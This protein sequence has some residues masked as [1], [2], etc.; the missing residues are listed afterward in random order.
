[1][2]NPWEDSGLHRCGRQ[3]DLKIAVKR[4]KNTNNL[5]ARVCNATVTGGTAGLSSA[6][7]TSKFVSCCNFNKLY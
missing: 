1:M 4:S 6:L 3:N 2:E 7:N 5:Q